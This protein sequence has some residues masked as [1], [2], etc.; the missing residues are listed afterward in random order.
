[1]TQSELD[2][3]RARLRK[4]SSG[5]WAVRRVQNLWRSNA[6]DGRTHPCVRAF[7]VPKRMYEIASDQ[8]EADATFMAHARQDVAALLA[9]FDGTRAILYDVRMALRE[10]MESGNLDQRNLE[11]IVSRLSAT[12]AQWSTA[13]KGSPS[14]F[15]E[16][17]TSR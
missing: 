16:V 12:C 7:R 8:V 5:P 2:E 10:L 13:C 14:Q 11:Q 3:I 1:M 6:G 17:S 9:E 4:A 15:Q